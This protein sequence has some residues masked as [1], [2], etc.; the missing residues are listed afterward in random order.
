[1]RIVS[2]HRRNDGNEHADR[3]QQSRTREQNTAGTLDV[4][5]YR[6]THLT[7]SAKHAVLH[8]PA[9]AHGSDFGVWDGEESVGANPRAFSAARIDV[10]SASAISTVDADD[11]NQSYESAALDRLIPQRHCRGTRLVGVRVHC[12][13]N[14]IEPV[15]E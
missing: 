15:V 3:R 1:M 12:R 14:L 8:D 10:V 2:T 4:P 11:A 5:P 6:R 13:R 7:M 9:V